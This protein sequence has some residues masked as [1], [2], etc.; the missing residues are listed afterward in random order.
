MGFGYCR[1]VWKGTEDATELPYLVTA[2]LDV[3]PTPEAK[4]WSVDPFAGTIKDGVVWG[5]GAIDLKNLV[6]GWMEA[7][8]D[9]LKHG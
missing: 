5:R 8:E 3:V 7:L 4:R 6:V 2:H 1:Y 9:M